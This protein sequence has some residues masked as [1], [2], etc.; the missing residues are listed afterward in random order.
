[1]D[2]SK[3]RFGD[4]S[5]GRLLRSI[6]PMY[7]IAPYIMK[8]KNDANNAYA[9]SVEISEVEKFIKKKRAEGFPGLGMLHVFLASYVRVI[10]QKPELNRFVSGQKVYARHNIEVVMMVKKEMSTTSGETSIKVIL[11]PR[12]TICHIYRKIN[13]EVEKIKNKSGQSDT[14]DISNLL[15]KFPRFMLR[16]IFATFR[17]LDYYGILPKSLI[18][19]S[20]F[21]GSMF[22]T[23]LGSLGIQPVT[24]HLYNFGNIPLFLAFGAKRRVNELNSDG[25]VAEKRYVDYILTIDDR[26]SDGFYFAQVCKYLKSFMRHPQQLDFPPETVIEDVD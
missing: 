19:S 9:D 16:L 24:H 15:V 1:M 18:D 4:R 3:K 20:L 7:K 10:S 22:V 6:D 13:I 2:K 21:H 26:I 5:D 17:F 12:D 11:D 23:D 8:T 25:T 14:D